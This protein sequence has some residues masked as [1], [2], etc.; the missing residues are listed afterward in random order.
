MTTETPQVPG[1]VPVLPKTERYLRNRP[2]LVINTVSRR[3]EG[4][5]TE[6]KGWMGVTGNVENFEQPV[7]VDRVND[8]HLRNASVIIDVL[9]ATVVK[10][11]FSEATDEEIVNHY[12]NK[13]R[14]Q[15]TE[16]M[17]LWLSQVAQKAVSA[18]Q[19]K[20]AKDGTYS[21]A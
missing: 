3:A 9:N 13:Y 14:A 10:N 15:L 7:V 5:K 17:D 12:M 2:F 6:K 1:P 20:R 11:R 8:T 16:A 18:E 4:V 19:D 21:I